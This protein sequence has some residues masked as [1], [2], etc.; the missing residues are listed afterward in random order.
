MEDTYIYNDNNAHV[1]SRA[2]SDEAET[3]TLHLTMIASE[4]SL[5]IPTTKSTSR[6]SLRLSSTEMQKHWR[7]TIQRSQI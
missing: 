6:K 1:V 5:S 2:Y 7:G 3:L 4:S